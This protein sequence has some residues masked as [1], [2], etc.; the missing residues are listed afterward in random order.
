MFPWPNSPVVPTR[1]RRATGSDRA[2]PP[3]PVPSGS[4]MPAPGRCRRRSR[5]YDHYTPGAYEFVRLQRLARHRPH[6][7]GP[8]RGT[9]DRTRAAVIKSLRSIKNCNG[10]G[11]LPIDINYSTVF[12]HDPLR[13][14]WVL[15]AGKSG[16]VPTRQRPSVAPTPRARVPGQ[17][18]R[19]PNLALTTSHQTQRGSADNP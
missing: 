12:G 7:Q 6:D 8:R 3:R 17:A 5:R 11:L 1:R 15:R 18:R 14:V 16:F 4:P 19:G 2:A 9:T 10:N 13:C